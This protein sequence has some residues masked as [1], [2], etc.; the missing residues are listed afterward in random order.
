[1][2]TTR[3]A[4]GLLCLI[5]LALSCT[6]S[7]TVPLAEPT[8]EFRSDLEKYSDA[9]A[10]A[11]ATY[12]QEEHIDERI[13][14]AF[15]HS[16]GNKLVG[17]SSEDDAHFPVQALL[18]SQADNPLTQKVEEWLRQQ[19]L[20]LQE[21]TP[22]ADALAKTYEDGQH[23][24]VHIHIPF[25]DEV[26]WS[27]PLLYSGAVERGSDLL[28]YR[29]TPNGPEEIIITEAM[30]RVQPTVVMVPTQRRTP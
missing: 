17:L 6:D 22:L 10:R 20:S 1:M 11:L 8:I 26:D 16:T 29:P 7:T 21:D 12:N 23:W 2:K 28:G 14:A 9:L 19:G 27:L 24:K 13:H 3:T 30:A 15:A 18:G 5:A 25:H 4:L